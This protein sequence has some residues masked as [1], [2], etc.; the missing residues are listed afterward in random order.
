MTTP[1][2]LALQQTPTG[3]AGS[4]LNAADVTPPPFGPETFGDLLRFSNVNLA[5]QATGAF[6]FFITDY[7][8]NRSISTSG[9]APNS[10]FTLAV[11]PGLTQAPVPEP[12]SLVLG[13][14][15]ILALIAWRKRKSAAA[16][17]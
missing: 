6:Q 7:S 11:V 8:S 9:K 14:T 12:G 10:S 4:I 1:Q 5:P 3:P 2:P 15:G 13:A 16:A 17:R